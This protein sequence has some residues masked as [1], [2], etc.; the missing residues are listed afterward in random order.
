MNKDLTR[1][2]FL[3]CGIYVPIGGSQDSQ[4]LHCIKDDGVVSAAR[5]Q[6]EE[7]TTKLLE[8]S[9]ETEIGDPFDDLE[10]NGIVIYLWK[11]GVITNLTVS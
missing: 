4:I 2:P 10:M 7:C 1:N 5:A 11:M 9:T 3:A 8:P 6:V